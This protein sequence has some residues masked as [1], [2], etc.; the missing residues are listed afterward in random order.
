MMSRKMKETDTEEEIREAF[1]V[2][3]AGNYTLK[4]CP[5][6]EIMSYSRKVA[7]R[8]RNVETTSH[9]RRCMTLH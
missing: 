9:Q 4:D 1:R 2:S 6:F 7:E 5:Q 3:D 8:A